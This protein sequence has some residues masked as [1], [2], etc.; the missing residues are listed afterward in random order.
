MVPVGHPGNASDPRTGFGRVDYEYNIS[1]YEVTIAQYAAF[2]NAVAASDPHGL[3]NSSM[4]TDQSIA[5][6]ARIGSPG[7]Y[8]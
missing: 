2:L 1:K 6:I 3:Y 5:G 4:T 8:R 7:S